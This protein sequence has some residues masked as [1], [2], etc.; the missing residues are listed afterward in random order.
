MLLVKTPLLLGVFIFLFSCEND[1]QVIRE[2]TAKQDSA[3]YSAFNVEIKYS[4]NGIT[5]GLMKAKLLNR[6]V[7]NHSETYLEFPEGVQM[8]F[9]DEQG[10]I[11]STLKADYSIF[12]E[13]KGEWIARYNVEVVNESNEK[14]NTEYLLWLRKEEKISSDQPV[15]ITT[16]E[17]VFYGENGFVSNQEFTDWEIIN[18]NDSFFDFKSD[19]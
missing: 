6:F 4:T 16:E 1:V 15:T 10:N 8:F 19:K 12:Y 5:N 17:G 18:I 2:L 7:D 9:Y 11:T 13:D 3:I 14:L